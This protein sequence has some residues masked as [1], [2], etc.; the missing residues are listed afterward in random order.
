MSGG[1]G[2][3]SASM[4]DERTTTTTSMMMTA[5]PKG[6]PWRRFG[7]RFRRPQ[8]QQ[9]Q[10]QQQFDASE[11]EGSP[12]PPSQSRQRRRRGTKA[13]ATDLAD[14]ARSLAGD[15]T[16]HK[17][18][19][20]KTSLPSLPNARGETAA[21]NVALAEADAD[22]PP[23]AAAGRQ[24]RRRRRERSGSISSS[25][26]DDDKE[27]G[28]TTDGSTRT[29]GNVSSGQ[30][31]KTRRDKPTTR[32]QTTAAPRRAAAVNLNDLKRWDEQDLKVFDGFYDAARRKVRR[33][34]LAADLGRCPRHA[35]AFKKRSWCVTLRTVA[36]RNARHGRHARRDQL[37]APASA[38]DRARRHRR[39]ALCAR[40][41]AQDQRRL[42]L[43]H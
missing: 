20:K 4:Q 18:A 40:E 37:L 28:S 36:Q 2:G 42:R 17:V 5:E 22:A 32:Q 8:Q 7:T 41:R 10:Q 39:V 26:D 27:Q 14:E 16:R 19:V 11:D 23:S 29:D 30:G 13:R 33:F 15:Q 35:G 43:G 6:S 3:A 25:A 38:R 24:R 12:P 34:F 21:S 9:Q 1:G 31:E